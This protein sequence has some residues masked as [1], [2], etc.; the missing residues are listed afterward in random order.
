MPAP[1]CEGENNPVELF[2]MP[3]PTQYPPG[4]ITF[5]VILLEDDDP[6]SI[7]IS[8]V[9]YDVDEDELELSSSNGEPNI[10][11][12]DNLLTITLPENYNGSDTITVLASDGQ[13]EVSTS[14]TLTVTPVNDAPILDDLLSD[15]TDEDIDFTLELSANDVD[16]EIG[17]ASCGERV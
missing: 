10:D 15:Q 1:S 7:D 16:E 13:D 3:F 17:R 8:N 4:G 11:I 9:F 12:N 14:F 5:N 6:H 2:I